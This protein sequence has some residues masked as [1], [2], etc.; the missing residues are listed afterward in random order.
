[1]VAQLAATP[2]VGRLFAL[3]MSSQAKALRAGA[4]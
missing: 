1:M 2:G 3:R 4:E